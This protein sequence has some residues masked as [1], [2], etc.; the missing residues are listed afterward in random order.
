VQFLSLAGNETLKGHSSPVPAIL[1]L[2]KLI[3]D[4]R[5]CRLCGGDKSGCSESEDLVT[6]V[7]IQDGFP[8]RRPRYWPENIRP[9]LGAALLRENKA[10]E[11]LT[12]FEKDL[13]PLKNPGNGWSLKGKELALRALGRDEEADVAAENFFEAWKFADVDIEAPCF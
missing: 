8:Y 1:D 5:L 11:A 7:A 3:L 9:C 10:D 6:A 4:A 2:S 12:V 13:S